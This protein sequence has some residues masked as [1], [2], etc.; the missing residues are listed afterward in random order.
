MCANHALSLF[1]MTLE[2][3]SERFNKEG[4]YPFHI[5]KE[6]YCRLIINIKLTNHS[7]QTMSHFVAWDGKVIH[8]RPHES[9]VNNTSDRADFQGSKLVF[10]KLY[11]N[12]K[13][14]V[15]ANY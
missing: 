12:K 14:P 8:D 10:G 4:G 6:H 15:M 7:K 3:V 2:R 13:V 9:R 1:G 5:L 11:N